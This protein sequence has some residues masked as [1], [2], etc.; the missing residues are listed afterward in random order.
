MWLEVAHNEKPFKG[1]VESSRAYL[2]LASYM[3][4]SDIKKAKSL[5]SD[6]VTYK[7]KACGQ[8]ITNIDLK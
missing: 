3:N 5:A 8:S 6:C 4:Q 7:Y 1:S 2:K